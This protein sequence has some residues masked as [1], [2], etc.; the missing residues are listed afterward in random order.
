MTSAAPYVPTTMT[1]VALDHVQ[2][3]AP[4][5]CEAVARRF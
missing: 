1:I 5:G 3:A 2:V 4:P